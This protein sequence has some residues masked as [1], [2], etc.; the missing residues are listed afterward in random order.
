MDFKN[1][2]QYFKKFLN[3]VDLEYETLLMCNNVPW[4]SRANTIWSTL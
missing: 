1:G 3:G 4:L 2:W